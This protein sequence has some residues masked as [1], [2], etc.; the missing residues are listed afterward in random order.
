VRIAVAH[1]MSNIEQVLDKVRAA[2]AKGEETPYHFIEVMACR[3]GC[4]GGGGQP[5]GATDEIRAKRM[6]GIYKDDEKSVIRCSHENPE[7]QRIYKEF[8]GE[9]LS[10][11]S[12]KYLHTHY[13]AKPTYRF[14]D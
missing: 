14:R 4:I 10:E 12:H 9:P 8:L 2:R 7:I 3:G 5:H 6:A 1:T 11:K 13:K